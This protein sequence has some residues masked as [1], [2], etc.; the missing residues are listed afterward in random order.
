M[1][2]NYV[3]KHSPDHDDSEYVSY[4][5]VDC[6]GAEFTGNKQTNKFTHSQILNFI[7]GIRTDVDS[8]V[9]SDIA[10]DFSCGLSRI[11]DTL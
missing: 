5:R 7:Y 1:R 10:Q 3:P 6:K 9:S 2:T 8:S 11:R 4:V